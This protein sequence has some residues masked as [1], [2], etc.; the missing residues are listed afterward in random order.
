VNV[1]D[2]GEVDDDVDD[3]GDDVDDVVD[4]VDVDDDADDR[5]RT[6]ANNDKFDATNYEVERNK[7]TMKSTPEA[8]EPEAPSH[9]H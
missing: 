8:P 4:D 5:R 3:V 6:H 9:M 7:P 2:V 1:D